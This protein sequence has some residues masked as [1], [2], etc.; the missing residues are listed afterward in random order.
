VQVPYDEGVANR[1]DP[2]SCAGFREGVCE[3]FQGSAQ[4]KLLNR[5]NDGRRRFACCGRQYGRARQRKCPPG[6]AWSENLACADGLCTGT[7]R[8]HGRPKVTLPRC[9]GPHRGGDPISNKRA[10]HSQAPNVAAARPEPPVR[11]ERFLMD[12]QHPE[13]NNGLEPR[14]RKLEAD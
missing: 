13:N 12:G 2:K 1:I 9:S 5:E 7:G 11:S 10:E 3:A 4:A 8:S 6:Q 14:R